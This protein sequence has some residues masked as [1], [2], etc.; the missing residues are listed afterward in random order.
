MAREKA[1]EKEEAPGAPPEK[2]HGALWVLREWA[3]ALVIAFLLAMF[4]RTFVVE[5]FKIPSGSMTPTLVGTA[6]P[7][8]D[9][10]GERVVEYDVDGNG[11]KDLILDGGP[12]AYSRPRYHIFYRQGGEFSRRN[13][14]V[15]DLDVPPEVWRKAR[16]RND[17]IL[18]NKFIYWFRRPQRGEI[19][20]F[21]VPPRIYERSKPIFI[22]RVVGLPGNVV[23]IHEP[24]LLVNGTTVTQPAVFNRIHY[25]SRNRGLYDSLNGGIKV[26]EGHYLVFGDNS[27]N[28]LD[29]RDWGPVDEDAI[30]GKAVFRYWPLDTWRFLK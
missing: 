18:V 10:S 23:E 15:N 7:E 27:T 19:V 1:D 20:V 8:Y 29:G 4:V 24:W 16:P 6:P 11:E 12:R 26:P 22:K 9:Y 25:V 28:S 5:L 13:E 17:R 14:E 3:D 21:R 30:K 2:P